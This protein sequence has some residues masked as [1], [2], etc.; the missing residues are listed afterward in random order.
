MN[1]DWYD[2]NMVDAGN[3][4]IFE[5]SPIDTTEHSAGFSARKIY[6]YIK[7]TTVVEPQR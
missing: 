6:E 2:P 1:T 4:R 3:N 5:L 7:Q